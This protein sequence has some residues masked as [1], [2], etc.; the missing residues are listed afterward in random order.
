MTE[1]LAAEQ[2]SASSRTSGCRPQVPQ[3]G[4]R[5]PA[6]G[7]LRRTRRIRRL[8][9]LTPAV[10]D[11]FLASRPRS[12]PR[13]FNHLRGVVAGLLE[14]AVTQDLLNSSPLALAGG[15]QAADR[16]SR[17]CSTSPRPAVCSTPRP[18]CQTTHERPNAARPITASSPSA[19]GWG[20]GPVR[21]AGCTS[22]TSTS[23]AD[24]LVVVGGKFGKTRLVPHGPRIA[25]L[26]ARAARAPPRRRPDAGRRRAA[27][28]LRRAPAASSRAPPA[29]S[30][31]DLSTTSTCCPRRRFAAAAARSPTL[32]R[33]RVPA[34]LVSRRARPIDPAASAVDLHGS[35][36]PRLDGG[37]PHDHPGIAGRGQSA[38]RGLR[39][40]GLAGG[41]S[42]S[43][44]PAA[45]ALSAL[46]LR[47]PP[48]HRQGS[49]ARLGA[50]LPRHDPAAAG[51]RRRRQGL[52]D[53]PL[54]T[55]RPHLRAGRRI[56]ATSRRRPRQPHPHPQP[57]TRGGAHPVRLHRH[58]DR[59]RCSA[60]A[61]GWPPSR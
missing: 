7:A 57:T 30:S 17:S 50:Q 27:V 13:S 52:Q 48:D 36:R 5:T 6:A 3:R 43:D 29:R 15:G 53:H 39:P 28:Q 41:S 46:V 34:A 9:Q 33:G 35:R 60:S 44:R 45:R 56:P 14:W 12:R 61:S 16:V 21:P 55:R 42:M 11:D 8:D 59:P 20:C 54:D 1:N 40:T 10:L 2:W 24:L 47:R 32:V 38:I 37:L 19:T 18:P 58:A 25:E 4:S 22:A 31:T 49:A 51:L 26:V 23:T